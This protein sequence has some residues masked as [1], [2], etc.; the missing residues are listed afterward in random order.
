MQWIVDGSTRQSGPGEQDAGDA[1]H[2][3][4]H[5]WGGMSQH[6]PSR[7][8]MPIRMQ[9]IVDGSTG[10]SGPGEQD[11]GDAPHAPGNVWGGTSQHQ[12]SRCSTPIRMQWIVDGS[13][14]R[15]GPGEQDA[16][17]ATPAH[18][19]EC[20]GRNVAAP[21]IKVQHAHQE[22]VDRG[23]QYTVEWAWRAGRW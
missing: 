12:P 7:C 6:H 8:S 2:V 13:T 3:P 16:G 4:G 1:P 14:G 20:V 5:V 9:W 18:A 21:P 23:R 11:A 15:K 22:V 19:R 10:R 17:D